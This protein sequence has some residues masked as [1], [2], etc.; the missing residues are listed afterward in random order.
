MVK[1]NHIASFVKHTPAFQIKKVCFGHPQNMSSVTICHLVRAPFNE[2]VRQCLGCLGSYKG[3]PTIFYAVTNAM[4]V[5]T[6]GG[7]GLRNSCTGHSIMAQVLTCGK[8]WLS[9]LI[10]VCCAVQCCAVLYC[11]VLYCT[12]LY[13]AVLC[14]TVLYCIVL[15]PVHLELTA[16]QPL[17]P[18]ARLP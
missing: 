4:M 18:F 9:T 15:S 5:F 11:A 8:F 7:T 10:N 6:I 1:C 12:V 14:C 16:Q 13:C 2:V 17:R 3:S